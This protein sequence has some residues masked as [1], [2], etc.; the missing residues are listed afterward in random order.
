MEAIFIDKLNT[1]PY[2]PQSNG[3]LERFHG[4]LVP[5]LKKAKDENMDCVKFLLIALYA[6]H[7]TP[8]VA[9]SYS[10]FALVYGRSM[11]SPVDLLWLEK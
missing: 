7:L 3:I 4:T 1:T 9:T 2:R 11:P 8:S 10:P 5:I 6:I